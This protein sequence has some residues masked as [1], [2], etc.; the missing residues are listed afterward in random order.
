MYSPT[1][2][3]RKVV[4]SYLPIFKTNQEGETS[5]GGWLGKMS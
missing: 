2:A 1:I 3:A 5:L 4:F